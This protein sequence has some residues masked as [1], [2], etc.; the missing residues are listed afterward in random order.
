MTHNPRNA[1]AF[2]ALMT[3]AGIG[4]IS[5]GLAHTNIWHPFQTLVLFAIAA[6]ASR[7]KIKLPGLT[8]NMSVN[9]PFLLIALVELNLVEALAVACASTAVQCFPKDLSKAKLDQVLFNLAT[10][11]F[12]TAL[13]WQILHTGA[14][15][16]AWLSASLLLPW[17]AATFFFGQTAPVSMII[18]LTGGGPLRMVWTSIAHLTFP[19]FVLSAGVAEISTVASRVIGWQIPLLVLP[20]M[21]GVFR[22]FQMYFHREMAAEEPRTMTAIAGT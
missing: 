20:L 9:L 2:I 10:I 3:A 12:S 13:A 4:V 7:M 1:N 8:G 11:S 17:A 16:N 6:A 15:G 18:T 22:S 19:Y 14:V 5:L 21:F